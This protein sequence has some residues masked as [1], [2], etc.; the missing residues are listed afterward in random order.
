MAP[1]L[2]VDA[3]LARA[4]RQSAGPSSRHRGGGPPL[5]AD[6]LVAG[7]DSLVEQ[8][9]VHRS[10]RRVRLADGGSG[11]GPEM[12]RRADE[13]LHEL[14]AAGGAP[15][16]AEAVARRLG[17]PAQVVAGLRAAGELVEVASGIDYPADVLAQLTQRLAAL[18]PATA[19]NTGLLAA[20][21]GVPRRYAQALRGHVTQRDRRPVE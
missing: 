12:R 9:I 13:L 16:R 15:P 19:T 6:E 4:S 18:P 7:L 21:L 8:G 5:G 11:L 20:A 2:R 14:R 10:G 1:D 3:L 17:L